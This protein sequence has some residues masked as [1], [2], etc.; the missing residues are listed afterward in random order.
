MIARYAVMENLYYQN[1]TM[2][3]RADYRAAL[4]QLCCKV[5]EWFASAFK[6]ANAMRDDTVNFL[7]QSQRAGAIWEEVKQ[8]DQACQKFTVVVE[9]KEEE[10]E[11]EDEGAETPGSEADIEDVS[12][13]GIDDDDWGVDRSKKS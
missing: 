5:L 12:D 8:M 10:S 1:P 13:E 2:T 6:L 11:S 7:T 9:A 4:L 3:L